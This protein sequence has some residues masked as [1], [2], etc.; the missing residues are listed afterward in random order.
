[1]TSELLNMEG[2]EAV[3][4]E[5]FKYRPKE[6]R[7][8]VLRKQEGRKSKA[9]EVGRPQMQRKRRKLCSGINPFAGLQKPEGILRTFAC[10]VTFLWRW[11]MRSPAETERG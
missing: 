6:D 5:K 9:Q 4:T 3:L 7:A 1:M 10:G 11:C 2:K 8:R